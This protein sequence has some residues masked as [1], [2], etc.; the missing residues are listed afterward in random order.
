[1]EEEEAKFF[2]E[3]DIIRKYGYEGLEGY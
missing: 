2:D 3:V 1:M